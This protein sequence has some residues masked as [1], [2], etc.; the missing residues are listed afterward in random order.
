MKC[1]NCSAELKGNTCEYCGCE[2]K[3]DANPQTQQPINIV[4]NNS[5]TNNNVNT[6]TNVNGARPYVHTKSKK[7]R[8]TAIFLC[9]LSFVGLSG[10]H[11]FYVGK[12]GSGLL[13]LF[14]FGY[15][16]IGTIVDLVSLVKGNF[17]DKY[18]LTLEK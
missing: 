12:K 4:I 15:M 2:V 6:N 9:C 16:W 11:R 7:S 13:H 18:G 1:P 10:F 8:S 5:N 14:T 17:T 3:T